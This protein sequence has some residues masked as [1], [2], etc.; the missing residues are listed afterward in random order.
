MPRRGVTYVPPR[1]QLCPGE[2][3][4]TSRGRIGGVLRV[5][6]VGAV[7][8]DDSGRIVVV[9]RAR[10]PS[11]GLWSIP[12]GRVEPGETLV[13]AARRE[14]LEETGLVVDVHEILGCVDIP[15]KNIVY[16][17]ADF[18][19]SVSGNV[20]PLTAGDDAGDARWVTA[21]E[22]RKLRTT[23]QLVQTLAAWGVWD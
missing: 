10:P 11:E 6:C 3:S 19:A 23:P 21:A 1:S 12:G 9:R 7:V 16:A 22:L 17:V 15:F 14:V 13:H 8:R 18:A 5:Q 4:G 20:P 2:E